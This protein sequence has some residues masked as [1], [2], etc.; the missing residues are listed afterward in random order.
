MIRVGEN[1][2]VIELEL[3]TEDYVETMEQL[4]YLM[5]INHDELIEKYYIGNLLIGMLPSMEQMNEWMALKN[6]VV[7]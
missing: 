6:R 4:T 7:S 5:E 3:C 1:K 2:I